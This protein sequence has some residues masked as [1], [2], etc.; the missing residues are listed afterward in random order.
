MSTRLSGLILKID[1]RAATCATELGMI[2]VSRA[3]PGLHSG[4]LAVAQRLRMTHFGVSWPNNGWLERNVETFP[5][6]NTIHGPK[7]HQYYSNVA[8]NTSTIECRIKVV[9]R[10]C[11][12]Y[13][14]ACP[15][16]PPIA[17]RHHYS[18]SCWQGV[19]LP[20]FEL[21]PQSSGDPCSAGTIIRGGCEYCSSGICVIGQFRNCFTHSSNN[22][23]MAFLLAVLLPATCFT[24]PD[25]K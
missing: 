7:S 1:R 19:D 25:S 2:L 12:R 18:R 23:G 5:M 24:A 21:V 4:L 17:H 10:F 14:V 13:I 3:W 9:V 22:G 6:L 15:S 20:S 16:Q 11:N 8:T